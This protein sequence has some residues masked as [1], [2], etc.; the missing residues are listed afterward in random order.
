M[1]QGDKGLLLCLALSVACQQETPS[2]VPAIRDADR[3]EHFFN[4]PFPS[5]ELDEQTG[6]RELSGYPVFG[7]DLTQPVIEGWRERAAMATSGY[8]NATAVYFRFTGPLD[9]L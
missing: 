5:A 1:P 2:G 7:L 6:G 3:G 4:H 9:L 8:G